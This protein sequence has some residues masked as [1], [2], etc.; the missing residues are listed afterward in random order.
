MPTYYNYSIIGHK[1]LEYPKPKR[2]EIKEIEED[3]CHDHK[4]DH[5]SLP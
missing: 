5:I 1:V 4:V 2:L 3:T